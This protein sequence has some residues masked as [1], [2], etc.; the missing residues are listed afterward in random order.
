VQPPRRLGIRRIASARPDSDP[1]WY[2]VDLRGR[3]INPDGLEDLHLSG[4][5]GDRYSIMEAV[6]T[7][8][9][10]RVRISR[11]AMAPEL[12]L[13][14][15]PRPTT[16]LVQSLRACLEKLSDR[17]LA[18]RLA[19]G[20]LSPPPE[21]RPG[22]NDG[23]HSAQRQAYDACLS[24][25]L[26]LVWGPP[27]TGKTWIIGAAIEELIRRGKRVLLVSP[28][29]VAV[30]NALASVAA[31]RQWEPG[32]L[33]RVGTPHLREITEDARISLSLLARARN[34]RLDNERKEIEEELQQMADV[35][36]R[37]ARLEGAV[38]S[39]RPPGAARQP[40][41]RVLA[42]PPMA[43]LRRL[44]GRLGRALLARP[45]GPQ[46]ES[47]A[48]QGVEADL[49]QLRTRVALGAARRRLLEQRHEDLL[50]RLDR[51]RR[52]VEGDIVRGARLVA[53]TLA[54]FRLHP[55][56][57]ERDYD[58]V[59]IDEVGAAATPE[60][61]LAVAKA[62]ETAVLF[63]DFLQLS[64]VN[65]HAEPLR[66]LDRAEVSKWLLDGVF[67]LCGVQNPRDA[68]DPEGRVIALT[69]QH[70]FGR[71][72]LELANRGAYGH[73]L[74]P[75]SDELV[76][77]R[78]HADGEGGGG[79][80]TDPDIVLLDTDELDD[81]GTVR[82]LRL[83]SGW[84]PAGSLIA[85]AL[86]HHHASA[87]QQ[88]GIV[89][90]YRSQAEA[91]VEALR[92]VEGRGP[93]SIE[94]GTVHGFQGREFDTVIFDLVEDGH[95]A[96][97]WVARGCWRGTPW[98]QD[99]ARLFNVGITRGRHRLYLICSRAA[100]ARAAEGTVLVDVKDMIAEG[101]VSVVPAAD[102]LAPTSSG[103]GSPLHRELGAVLA[104]YVRVV[105][106]HDEH[107]FFDALEGY[108]RG[109]RE[110]IWIWAPWVADRL[111][112][113]LPLLGAAVERG[114]D[115]TVF[116]RPDTDR[117]MRQ[118]RHQEWA[119]KLERVVPRVV[120]VEEMHQKIVVVDERVTMVGSCNTL[121]HRASREIMVVHEGRRFAARL[122]EHEHAD[123]FRSPPACP[124]CGPGTVELRRSSSP[125]RDFA[126]YW[127]CATA[128][129]GWQ[130]TI[131]RGRGP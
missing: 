79:G 23:F 5:D 93:L 128:G 58:V 27:G 125:A 15:V 24:A 116:L 35:A 68:L 41:H 65:Q 20:D 66:R 45:A 9:V 43:G 72:V 36:R 130:R 1:G 49:A 26:F 6:Q 52:D 114:V 63:G 103:G 28:T 131:P 53:T 64:P 76:G 40:H 33:V 109:A 111:R 60:V 25:G 122:L 83:I 29:N 110:S 16:F 13:R 30:D 126:W 85:T 108:L 119:R 91:A 18:S 101:K 124:R 84:W 88:V 3:Q 57:Y 94:V 129:C 11:H 21:R 82:R 67:A 121:S 48:M 77:G 81:L 19:S 113:V 38:A 95:A 98:E 12:E 34:G 14:G 70:R 56:V 89:T 112:R 17:G 37:L 47:A 90:P 100:I 42:G 80:E 105:G 127:R 51:L 10:L 117:L 86:A 99:G 22:S 78:D 61:V 7:G 96:A 120:R 118:T 62:R 54:R 69:R 115:V 75:A 2:V 106:I 55:S 71:G 32:Q 50:T 44:A 4:Q 107:E 31:R 104:Q 92:D 8:D 73:T 123:L 59:L 97:G 74:R 39:R 46:V 102:V 87:G